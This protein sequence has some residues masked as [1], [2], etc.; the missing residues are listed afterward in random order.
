MKLILDNGKEIELP[1]DSFRR[2]LVTARSSLTRL[3]NA[4]AEGFPMVD[5]DA[6]KLITQIQF[7]D[8][9]LI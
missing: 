3:K 7:N 1:N 5:R 6:L 4:E 8:Q 9:S 2:I